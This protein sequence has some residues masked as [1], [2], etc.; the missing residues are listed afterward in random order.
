[1]FTDL[2]IYSATRRKSAFM[3]F[4][5][6]TYRS[7]LKSELVT[8]ITANP[9][10]SLRAFS[11]AL[12]MTP[13]GLSQ[14][15]KGTKNLSQASALRVASKLGLS[16]DETEFFVQLVQ[17]ESAKDPEH[18]AAVQL[19]MRKHRPNNPAQ[20]LSVDAF[21]MLSDWYH[22]PIL[23]MTDLKGFTLSSKS[24]SERLGISVLE[25]DVAIDRLARLDLLK[26]DDKGRLIRD[27]DYWVVS[28]KIPNAALRHYHRQM[29][30]RAIESLESQ[31]P[32]EKI[33]GSETFALDPKL[34]PQ[35]E[36]IAERFFGEM[37][38]LASTSKRPS[39]IYHFGL[40][41]FRLTK[42]E[43]V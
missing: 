11:K 33:V 31:S 42:K 28:A 30:G 4:D 38:E 43:K 32:Q 13:S 10:Y 5:H 41:F 23:M 9:A 20:D 14:V 40:Q 3:I 35:A 15:L 12:Q 2:L 29:L 7:F 1:L 36:R 6:T 19:R 21:K 17:F 27:Q 24:V 22:L 16:P 18:K 34:L 37:K 8:R 26:R 25:A 39:E